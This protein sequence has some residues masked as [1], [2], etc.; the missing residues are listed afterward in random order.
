M[1]PLL[2]SIGGAS[3]YA[4]RG[5]LDDWPDEF[6]F[7]PL[8]N[9][10]PGGIYTS[11]I[12]TITGI[13]YKAKVT[14]SGVGSFSVNGSAF[15]TSPKFIRNNEVI[16]I[17]IPTTSGTFNDFNKNYTATI[18]VGKRSSS[19]N[20]STRNIN[21]TPTNFD[22]TDLFNQNVGTSVTSNT[23]RI[24]GLEPGIAFPIRVTSGIGSV[25][26]NG[27]TPIYSGTIL[28]GN[29]VF[30]RTT[31]SNT[32]STK[33]S[34]IVLVGSYSTDFNTTTR[35]VDLIPNQFSFVDQVNVGFSTLIT[36]NTIT[37]SG[38]DTGQFAKAT[39]APNTFEFNV[40][41]SSGNTLYPYTP[42]EKDVAVGNKITLRTISSNLPS[43]KTTGT[44][45][46][47]GI[48][49]PFS[50][51]TRPPAYD[52]VP[53]QFS[54][55]DLNNLNLNTLTESDDITLTGISTGFFATASINNGEYRV[56]RN[57][58]V[59][60][61]YTTEPF[62]VTLNDVIRLRRTTSSFSEQSITV[63]FQIT[64]VDTSN[65]ID[66]VSSTISDNW[67][68][69]TKLLD[70]IAD[71]K[72]LSSISNAPLSTLRTTSFVAT[73]FDDGCNMK[74]STSNVNSYLTVGGITGTSNLTV[75]PNQTVNVFMTSSA[76]Y[77]DTRTTSI[78]LK[79]DN[80]TQSTSFNWS[81]ST[82]SLDCIPTGTPLTLGPGARCS[83]LVT[84][85]NQ[86]S[87]DYLSVAPVNT[88]AGVSEH[89]IQFNI[90]NFDDVCGIFDVGGTG[91]RASLS[92]TTLSSTQKSL[93]VTLKSPSGFRDESN[94]QGDSFFDLSLFRRSTSERVFGPV[95]F[96]CRSCSRAQ[97]QARVNAGC[98]A[99][100]PTLSST[101]TH[102]Y[103]DST[104]TTTSLTWG[105]PI[106]SVNAVRFGSDPESR[107]YDIFFSGTPFSS[108][109]LSFSTTAANGG[110]QPSMRV[111]SFVKIS[112]NQWRL[113]F[114]RLRDG[115]YINSF[116]R[117][118]TI[119]VV[120]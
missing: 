107:Y 18:T 72:S 49:A 14:I 94:Y 50:V 8:I 38:I 13:N 15:N 69:T 63:S 45:S 100:L 3:E 111:R 29:N 89:L 68:I 96:S 1:S 22:F 39:I 51:T 110:S 84:D 7:T 76:N 55:I 88:P 19:W 95:R 66:G 65:S 91:T 99:P 114:E 77:S 56:V 74:I 64:G 113:T 53:N 10:E 75:L 104:A 118:F 90:S 119:G 116:N 27:A 54:F 31:T 98:Y 32:Y 93:V 24:N 102:F 85:V 80:L 30:V 36:S 52:T 46:V 23:I 28:N 35:V 60:K 73:G 78:N 44:L 115:V 20:L 41:D 61:N 82:L 4:Y 71:S 83:A 92:I 101:V 12:T 103:S 62:E 33:N 81:V 26:I 57:G 117:E 37:I 5:N 25:S 58:V 79:S 97:Y 48:S 17:R 42:F 106:T 6:S 109:V 34:S 43:T 112:S 70:C 2:G 59:V 16:S 21:S 120:Y 40:V 87:Y 86:Q 47:T 108:S 105:S 11:G 9:Q 67:T